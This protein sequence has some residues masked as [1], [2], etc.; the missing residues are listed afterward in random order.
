LINSGIQPGVVSPDIP[1]AR[2]TPAEPGP[3]E[4]RELTD[5]I[6][7][8]RGE[9]TAASPQ[10][11]R[12]KD[13][14][15]ELAIALVERHEQGC[16]PLE[17]TRTADL[18][19]A[20]CYGERLLAQDSA[21][22][23]DGSRFVAASAHYY[24]FLLAED[25]ADLDAMISHLSELAADYDADDPP[26]D[27][28][29]MLGDALTMRYG[30]VPAGA[31][32]EG[33]DLSR[34]IE[35]NTVVRPLLADEDPAKTIC[36]TDLGML[37]YDRHLRRPP[38]A[39]HQ[40]VSE[41]ADL[42]AAIECFRWLRLAAPRGDPIVTEGVTRLGMALA[43]RVLKYGNAPADVDEAIA[44]LASAGRLLPA[45]DFRRPLAVLYLGV[46][47]GV[48]FTMHG[49]DSADRS[50][51]VT[52]LR[53]VVGQAGLEVEQANLARLWLGQL[54]IIHFI[55]DGLRLDLGYD[56]TSLWQRLDWT[57]ADRMREILATDRVRAEAREAAQHL[58]RLIEMSGDIPDLFVTGTCLLGAALLV[59]GPEGMTDEDLDRAVQCFDVAARRMVPRDDG[60]L[61]IAAIHAWLLSERAC[62]PGH[63]ADSEP[64]AE[65]LA[66]SRDRLSREHPLRPVILY[67]L[68]LMLALEFTRRPSA[69]IA[70]AAI[71]ALSDALGWMD[72]DHPLRTQTLTM[73]GAAFLG[74][75]Q[76]D[77]PS[78]PIDRIVD[79]LSE[80]R[81]R[82]IAD[83]LTRAVTLMAYGSALHLQA[84]RDPGHDGLAAGVTTLKQA[85]GLVPEGHPLQSHMFLMLGSMLV[86]HYTLVGNL[87]SLEAAQ[88]YLNKADQLVA[89]ADGPAYNPA[90]TDRCSVWAVRGHVLIHLA[91]RREDPALAEAAI[92]DL[93]AALA[94]YPPDQPFRGMI[95]SNLGTATIWRGILRRSMRDIL[96]AWPQVLAAAEGLPQGN[97]ARSGLLGRAGMMCVAHARLTRNLRL[98]DK[99]IGLLR[100]AAD[101]ELVFHAEHSRP[102]MGVGQAMV[103]RF[104]V[105]RNPADLNE[106]IAH[107]EAARRALAIEPGNSAAAHVLASLAEAYR[108]R[109]D[110]VRGD[111]HAAINVAIAALREQVGD[112]LLQSGP[113]RA[114]TMARMTA[115]DAAEIAGWALEARVPAAA[116][117]ALELGR[118]LVLH[119][120]TV[121][122]DLPTRLR[123]AGHGPLADEWDRAARAAGAGSGISAAL[124]WDAEDYSLLD[125]AP[126]DR[127]GRLAAGLAD[128]LA[129]P[130]IPSDLRHR[131]LMALERSAPRGGL[132]D[133]PT[134]PEIA[135]AI[136]ATGRD[137]LAYLF[138]TGEDASGSGC[139]VLIGAGGAADVVE[140]PRINRRTIRRIDRYA[141]AQQ[142]AVRRDPQNKLRREARFT[143]TL[144]EI[145][146]WAWEA[147]VGPILERIGARLPGLPGQ[148][149]LIPCGKLAAVPWHAARRR[150]ADGRLRYAI[151][152]GVFSY[153]ASA[154]QF[155][156]TARRDRLPTQTGVVIV[157]D[158]VGEDI[159]WATL[160]AKYIRAAFYPDSRYLGSRRPDLATPAQVLERMP[161]RDSPGASILHLSCHATASTSPE[162]S[163]LRMA[164]E[165]PLPVSSILD[166][167]R[168]RPA[169]SPG[170]LVVLSACMSDLAIRDYDEA[171]TLATA[172]LAAGAV[173][174]VGSRWQVGDVRTAL[175]MFMFHH[176]LGAGERPSFA[177]RSAQLWMLDPHR[178]IP[179]LM[180]EGLADEV[181]RHEL[182]DESVWAAFAHQGQ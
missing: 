64:A 115:A 97:P 173:S 94:S 119:A 21:G 142:E 102:M 169:D 32:T 46:L 109:A 75:A 14:L 159:P 132:L 110:P 43:E 79:L 95:A 157:A 60:Q 39:P 20:I 105:S 3:P 133:L 59:Q 42:S 85:T 126:E 96:T 63:E 12:A 6:T 155:I 25:P 91:V 150:A 40:S 153:A 104:E 5:Y 36:V 44:A 22:A 141:A 82:P 162:R 30:A 176:Y 72:E 18:D 57:T 170:G 53:E 118:G 134:V 93:S 38:A 4:C 78:L 172:F 50:M 100:Q 123:T 49:G 88:Y 161:G 129:G 168:G 67:R 92:A 158:P 122:A 11:E 41:H 35:L 179:V 144:G 65:L 68:A 26:V 171:L 29:A 80:A 117:E 120:A 130:A 47:L 45:D 8:L 99:G 101:A 103:L 114:L 19:S 181:T 33:A 28:L 34:A 62:R 74:M 182:S 87:E 31:A 73:L 151:E 149:M 124:P 147:A 83:P 121:S 160:E 16:G 69:A 98:L 7:I 55:P 148:V 167:A 52:R 2:R 107:M 164:E 137:M 48:R 163:H 113:Q 116:V 135:T 17:G 131:A 175:L 127:Q 140:L 125:G 174:V 56:M 145:C 111:L 81:A 66:S 108:K 128:Q 143:A 165:E 51:A 177:L 178:V 138:V 76:F 71:E 112:V 54:L 27:V 106:G 139:A 154:R 152:D 77:L 180:P 58:G 10:S 1:A 146:E 15:A 136:A 90:R 23:R 156:E 37:L 13:L 166:R 9:L 70:S 84:I 24:R 61:E 86:D 89:A